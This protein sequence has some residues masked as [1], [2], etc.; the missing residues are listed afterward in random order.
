MSRFNLAKQGLSALL[1][2]EEEI[3]RSD[4]RAMISATRRVLPL[5]PVAQPGRAPVSKTGGSKFNPWRACR[6]GLSQ[7]MAAG[8][9]RPGSRVRPATQVRILPPSLCSPARG[10]PRRRATARGGVDTISARYA[11]RGQGWTKFCP[12]CLWPC[13]P[14]CVPLRTRRAQGPICYRSGRSGM[15]IATVSRAAP[16]SVPIIASVIMSMSLF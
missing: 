2:S 9:S 8:L 7:E 13:A 12:R 1:V 6:W 3:T 5:T 14:W 15:S 10:R 11:P 16:I 4:D